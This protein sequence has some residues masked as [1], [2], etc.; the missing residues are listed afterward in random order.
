MPLKQT[1]IVHKRLTLMK[2]YISFNSLS[3]KRSSMLKAFLHKVI[4]GPGLVYLDA[5][6]TQYL[7]FVFWFEMLIPVDAILSPFQL[8]KVE[9]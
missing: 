5:S 1:V 2:D 3:C 9:I 8:Q 6:N 4:R 7:A